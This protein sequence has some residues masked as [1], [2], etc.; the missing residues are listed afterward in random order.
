MKNQG[1]ELLHNPSY[2]LTCKMFPWSKGNCIHKEY[3]LNARLGTSLMV[4]WL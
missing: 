1:S 3:K 2:L 4:Q